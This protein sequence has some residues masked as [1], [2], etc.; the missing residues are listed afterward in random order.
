MIRDCKEAGE[1]TLK[2]TWPEA[3]KQNFWGQ[4]GHGVNSRSVV[5]AGGSHVFEILSFWNGYKNKT[6]ITGSEL[7]KNIPPRCEGSFYVEASNRNRCINLG[8]VA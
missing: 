1:M 3:L 2:T 8:K 4:M 5:F 7:V 6:L